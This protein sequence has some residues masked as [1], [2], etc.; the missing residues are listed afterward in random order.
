MKVDSE[1]EAE[2]EGAEEGGEG[3]EGEAEGK[4]ELVR[5]FIILIRRLVYFLMKGIGY[6]LFNRMLLMILMFS[7]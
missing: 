5:F 1:R 7:V 4:G 6:L 2:V 3:G